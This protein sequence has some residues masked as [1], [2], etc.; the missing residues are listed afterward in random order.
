MS[1]LFARKPLADLQPPEGGQSLKRVLLSSNP[2]V[3]GL[4][5]SAPQPVGIPILVNLPACPP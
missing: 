4:L 5:Q 2:D 3:H 1:Q